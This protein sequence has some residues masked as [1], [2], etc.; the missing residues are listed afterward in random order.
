MV[1]QY[2]AV[3]GWRAIGSTILARHGRE[4]EARADLELLARRGFSAIP[5]DLIWTSAVAF[6]AETAALVGAEP[7]QA[8]E[9]YDLLAPIGHL[10][11]VLGWSLY[12]G[13]V[14]RRQALLAALL[15][16]W[17]AAEAHFV[18]ATEADRRLGA[19]ASLAQTKA[20]YAA[21][22]ARYGAP[23]PG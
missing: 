14:A 12:D 23:T 11:V 21:A 1:D 19:T 17:D 10:N 4:D 2:P 18:A 16:R 20:D 7:G 13:P 5:R 3:A 15:G 6:A 8:E 9:L 22:L